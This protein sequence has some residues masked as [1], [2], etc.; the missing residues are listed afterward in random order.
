MHTPQRA[1]YTLVVL[2]ISTTRSWQKHV[3]SQARDESARL[4]GPEAA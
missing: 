3:A 4:N 1:E 2:Q